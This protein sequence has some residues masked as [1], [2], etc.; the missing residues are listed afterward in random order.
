MRI[1]GLLR[2]A[3]ALAGVACLHGIGAGEVSGQSTAGSSV[4]SG[5]SLLLINPETRVG[6]VGFRFAS[7]SALPVQRLRR[8]IAFD[9]P[10]PAPGL[11]RTFDFL[12]GVNAPELEHFSP[13]TLQKDVARLRRLFRTAG[14]PNVSVDYDVVLDTAKNEVDVTFL[15]DQD[16]PVVV[17][18][19]E[20]RLVRSTASADSAL[21]EQSAGPVLP[22]ALE[23]AWVGHLEWLRAR[24]GRRFGQQERAQLKNQ[25]A[26]WFLRRGYPWVDVAVAR[27]DTMGTTVDVELLISLGRRARVREV[28]VEGRVRLS[29]GVV[30]REIPIRVG[31][32]YDTRRVAA[33]E[34]E[35]YELDLVTRA[36]GN[37]V[38]GR[39]S[40]STVALRFRIEEAK[41][42]LV[43]GR[44]GWRSEAGVAAETHWLHR[45]FFGGA[46]TFTVSTTAETGWA[47]VEHARGRSV[48]VSALVR[49]PYIVH[50]SVSGTFGPFL[51]WRDD[52]GDRSLLFGIE[53]AAIYRRTPLETFTLQHE[54]S[55]LRVDDAL[56]LLAI[57]E[58][59]ENGPEP[60]EPVFIKSVFRINASYGK[61]DDRLDPRAGFLVEPAMQVTGP[62]GVSDI[63]FVRVGLQV[64]AARPLSRRTGLFVRA[65]GGRLFPFGDSDL[66]TPDTRGRALAGLRSVMFRAGGTADV[67]GWGVGLVGPR[68]PE[69]EVNEDGDVVSDRYVPVGGLARLTGSVELGLPFPFLPEPHRTYVFFDAGRVWSPGRAVV[70]DDPEL[71]LDPWAFAVGGGLQFAT[72]VGPIRFGVGYKL[73]PTRVDLLAPGDVAADLASGGDLS[74]LST[75][76]RRRW[77]LHFSI[78]RP[79]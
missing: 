53:T 16:V 30:R 4:A 57:Q 35:L 41:P 44:L 55:R 26:D 9:G 51:R 76:G 13:L 24:R 48:G 25:T 54:F 47:A 1:D 60:F 79:L 77:H 62:S 61:L 73:N 74:G 49:Q 43:W 50:R 52:F 56:Q 29:E 19:V 59:V 39:S 27:E 28:V 66:G 8:S 75:D 15:I 11:R 63:E 72:L 10:G 70:P 21:V 2:G 71:A 32:W 45:D 34:R 17:G 20:T 23:G 78:G 58:I 3:W 12:P 38:E 69:V 6:A 5:P 46:R 37:I 36:L 14:F 22:P 18:E 42:R 67:R 33:G 7:G 64:V 65:S 31:D 68:I 40:D